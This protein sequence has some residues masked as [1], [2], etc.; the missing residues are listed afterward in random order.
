MGKSQRLPFRT[1]VSVYSPL[2]LIFTYLWGPSH[3]TLYVGHKYYVSFIDAFSRYTWIFPRLK[4]F[5]FFKLSS[6]WLNCNLTLKSRVFN[7]IGGWIQTFLYSLNLLW[8]LSQTNLSPQSSPKWCG[9][10]KIQ[11]YSW[12]GPYIVVSCFFTLTVLGLCFYYNC[13]SD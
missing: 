9:W 8:H 1:F 6:L 7:L 12:L 3:L 2:E 13:L 5:L 4:L 11:T 10:K